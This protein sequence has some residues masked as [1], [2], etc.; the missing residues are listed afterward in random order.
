M[1]LRQLIRELSDYAEDGDVEVFLAPEGYTRDLK[2][3]D[4]SGAFG[5]M[6][7]EHTKLE[8]VIIIGIPGSTL[9]E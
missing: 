8:R 4:T 7:K 3:L 2:L 9:S 5:I 1:K 6:N